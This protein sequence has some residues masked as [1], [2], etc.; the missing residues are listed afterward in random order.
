MNVKIQLTAGGGVGVG[1]EVN[2]SI[3]GSA[4][5]IYKPA[6]DYQKV[7]LDASGKVSLILGWYEKSYG[8][9]RNIV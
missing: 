3:S 4:N 9:L 5:Y 7:W 8:N 6:R 1:V 2:A